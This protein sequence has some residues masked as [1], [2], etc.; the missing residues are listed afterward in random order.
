MTDVFMRRREDTERHTG[1][2]AMKN[3]GRDWSD[4]A[5][6]QRM[7]RIATNQQKPEE[8]RKHFFP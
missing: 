7:S 8:S 4:A 1:R 3:R 6:S 2:K 5:T